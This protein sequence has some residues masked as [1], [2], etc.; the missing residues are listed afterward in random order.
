MKFMRLPDEFCGNNSM[1]V[2]IPVPYEGD[3]S[4]GRGASAGPSEIITASEHLEYYDE[5]LDCEPFEKG[6]EVAEPLACSEDPEEAHKQIVRHV[7]KF[8]RNF[9]IGLGG[10][11]SVSS[12]FVEALSKKCP[13]LSVLIFDAHSDLRYSWNN[14]VWNHAC[15]ARRIACK[16]KVGI[17]GG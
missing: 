3:V 2:I 15:V 17:V 13:D 1:S 7:E 16:H 14:S 8:G 12:A 11:H 4:F 10:D 9:V 5:E 6:I